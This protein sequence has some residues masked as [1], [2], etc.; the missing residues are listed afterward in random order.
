MLENLDYVLLTIDE[1]ID[2]GHAPRYKLE[3]RSYCASIILETDVDEIVKRVSLKSAQ[4][5]DTPIGEQTISQA[6]DTAKE[7]LIKSF[8]S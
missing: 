1:M 8:L 3:W 2:G 5:S 7:Q 6:F 4:N